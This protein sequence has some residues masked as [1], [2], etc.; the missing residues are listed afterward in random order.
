M[1]RIVTFRCASIKFDFYDSER[2]PVGLSECKYYLT[3]HRLELIERW[4]KV[5]GFD[6]IRT[7]EQMQMLISTK[8]LGTY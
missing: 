5:N 7:K 4:I 6:K 8:L 3:P 2:V 1:G